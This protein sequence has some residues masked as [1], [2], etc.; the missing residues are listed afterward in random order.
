MILLELI[1]VFFDAIIGLISFI[2]GVFDV[3]GDGNGNALIGN[4]FNSDTYETLQELF[5]LVDYFLPIPQM[6]GLFLLSSGYDIVITV[7]RL[8]LRIKSFIPTMGN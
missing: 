4:F 8:I 7:W 3:V 5:R 2:F 1:K 6:I